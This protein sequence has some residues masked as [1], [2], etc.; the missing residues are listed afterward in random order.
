MATEQVH[1]SLGDR[2]A[3]EA[4]VRQEFGC[5]LNDLM[6][7]LL[8]MQQDGEITVTRDDITRHKGRYSAA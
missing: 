7:T 1:I 6:R 5:S 2:W 3:L 8:R 4:K